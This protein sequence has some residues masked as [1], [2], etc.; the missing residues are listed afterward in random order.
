MEKRQKKWHFWRTG[1]V[2]S[3]EA[4]GISKYVPFRKK[5]GH[6]PTGILVHK[7]RAT[8]FSSVS[9]L[10]HVKGPGNFGIDMIAKGLDIGTTNDAVS[11][12]TVPAVALAKKRGKEN[13]FCENRN[14]NLH[15][16][17]F[18]LNDEKEQKKLKHERLKEM[19]DSNNG[20]GVLL[21]ET[22]FIKPRISNGVS[23]KEVKTNLTVKNLEQDKKCEK[24]KEPRDGKPH[25]GRKVLHCQKLD[26]AGAQPG[27]GMESW[28][29]QTNPMKFYNADIYATIPLPQG[30]ELTTVAGI[31]LPP[32]AV[33]HALQFLEFCA[34]FEEVNDSYLF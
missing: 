11:T 15:P 23:K 3:A 32:E 27:N 1:I 8:G 14:S 21:K 13:S 34:A 5:Q 4:S 30:T 2:R 10:L 9:E 18:P 7:A 20:D 25:K 17:R 19:Q 28:K 12:N 6:Q 31:N 24:S 22:S 16:P 26:K 29:Y 33:G